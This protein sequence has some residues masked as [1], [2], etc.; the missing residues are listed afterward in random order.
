MIYKVPESA[1]VK[2]VREMTKEDVP[3]VFT[4]LGEYL[5]RFQIHP[6]F[7]KEKLEHMTLPREGMIYSYVVED[8][9]KTITDFVSFY[10]LP[11]TVLK[12]PTIKEYNVS[13]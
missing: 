4:L 1:D 12:H 9:K 13:F 3:Q 2:G 5:K 8:E 11:Y 10:I 6:I 7:T